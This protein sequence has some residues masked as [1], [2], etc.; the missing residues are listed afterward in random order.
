MKHMK[1]RIILGFM[2]LLI[3]GSSIFYANVTQK[4]KA[5]EIYLI[6]T[7]IEEIDISVND[8]SNAISSLRL[9]QDDKLF[10][11]EVT[12][13][14]EIRQK[15]RSLMNSMLYTGRKTPSKEEKMFG[16]Y[17][18]ELASLMSEMSLYEMTADSIIEQSSDFFVASK[19]ISNIN[20]QDF[21]NLEKLYEVLATEISMN[22]GKFP[23][24]KIFRGYMESYNRFYED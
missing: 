10:Y 11:S 3:I 15:C 21:D 16:Y 6:T 1:F 14:T 4:Y 13:M 17:L 18:G 19:I 2:A 22:A 24:N 9:D 23:E 5:R 20:L 7:G 12:I 8:F